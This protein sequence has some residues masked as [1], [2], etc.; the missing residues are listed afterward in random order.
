MRIGVYC[1]RLDRTGAPIILLR[2]IRNL[3]KRH[4]IEL[5]LPGAGINTLLPE[6]EA[7]GV[8]CH[9]GIRPAELDVFLLN[10][11]I[12]GPIL[13]QMANLVPTVYWVHEPRGGMAFFENGKTD[14]RAFDLASRVVFPTLWQ[15]ETLFKP[16]LTHDNWE[17]VPYGIGTDPAPQP[18]PFVKQPGKFYLLHLGMLDARK[19]QDMTVRALELL[20]NPDIEVFFCGD[21]T[22]APGY[23]ERLKAF[24]DERPLLRDRAHFMGSVPEATVNAYIQ[25]CDA[26]VFPTRDDLITLVIL[27]SMFF[28]RCVISSDFGPIPETL[29]HGENGLLFPVDDAEAMAANID[30]VYRDRGLL[31]R[32]GAAA[33]LR[34]EERHSFESHVAGMERVLTSVARTG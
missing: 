7:L 1:H 6:Y 33:R 18:C 8:R 29:T 31:E 11:L 12:S 26:S 27:E 25:H 22:I 16:Y 20:N 5:L 23:T 9:Q 34:Y 28:G 30:R 13:V 21:P 14:P 15:A 19:G 32:L 17:V 4:Q 10:T 3:A 2:L 24:V